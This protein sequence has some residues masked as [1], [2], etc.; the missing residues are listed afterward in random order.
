[1]GECDH[2]KVINFVSDT[3]EKDRHPVGTGEKSVPTAVK[4]PF[5]EERCVGCEK[6]EALEGEL[7]EVR[8]VGWG[9]PQG[10]GMGVADQGGW[11]R[12]ACVWCVFTWA[13]AQQ[14]WFS[15]FTLC[16]RQ[17]SHYAQIVP[18]YSNCTGRQSCLQNKRSSRAN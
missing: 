9:S 11:E 7:S 2:S 4:W 17:S 5:L 10:R 18:Q 12:W 3:R 13:S 1:M 15:A 16:F 14:V 8:G 6:S